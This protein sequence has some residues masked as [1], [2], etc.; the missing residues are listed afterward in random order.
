MSKE[1]VPDIH[2]DTLYR[3]YYEQLF[4][5]AFQFVRDEEECYDIVSG[6]FEKLWLHL[7][8]RPMDNVAAYLFTVVRNRSIDALRRQKRQEKYVAFTELLMTEYV[9]EQEYE[10]DNYNKLLIDRVLEALPSPPTREILVACYLEEKKY[11]EVAEEM[12]ITVATVK[13]HMVRALK[14]IRTLKDSIR[15]A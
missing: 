5:F 12:S 8:Q 11:R 7:S 1:N 10:S 13:K 14:I 3:N 2:F 4:R 15:K 9:E 6:A